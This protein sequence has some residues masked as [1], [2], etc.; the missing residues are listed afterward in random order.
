[1]RV[2]LRL[3]L[4]LVATCAPVVPSSRRRTWRDQW[5]ADLWHYAQWL[6]AHGSAPAPGSSLAL[7]ARSAGCI[8]HACALRIDDWSLRMVSHDLKFACRM[9]VRRPAFTLVAILILGLGIGANAT[10]FSWVQTV[11]LQPVP[12]VDV[13]PLVSLS[14]RTTSRRNLSFSYPNFI[15]LRGARPDGL[16]DVIAFRGVAMN[17]RGDGEPRRVWG[18]LV[19]PN[20]FDVLRLRPVLGRGFLESDASA[21]DREPVAVL[22]YGAWQGLFAGDPRIVGRR[23][24]L[25]ARPF[26]V[27]GVAPEGFRGTMIGLSLDVFV[28]ITMQRA[29]MSG[30]DRLSQ[31][32]SAFL[33]VFG[34]LSEGSTLQRAQAS[35]DVVAARL[36]EAHPV[37]EGRG[38]AVEPL[39][40]TG[41]A[42]MLLPVMA[43][44]MAVV[45]VVLLIAC[46]NL[47]GLLL[48]RAAGRQRE[49]AVRLAVG[50]S[51]GRLV[52]QLLLESVL[53]AAAGGVAGVV[54]AVWTS[55]TLMTFMPPT[56]FPVAFDAG[57]DLGVVMFAIAVTFVT[58]L[59]FGLLPALRASRPDVNAV[60]KD[61]AGSVGGGAAR[62][63]I[64]NALVVAQVAL[65]LVLLVCAALFVR[66]LNHARSLDPGFSL[67]EGVMAAVD[68]LPN[69]YDAVRGT[70][71]HHRLLEQVRALP[72]VEA[73]TI[74]SNMP[75]DIGRGSEM[76]VDIEGY[77]PAPNEEVD[78]FYNRVGPSY[79]DTMGIPIV[80]GRPLDHRDIDGSQLSVVVNETMAGRYW[81]G[82]DPIGRTIRF[83]A[84]PAIVVG[85]ATDGKYGQ[86][87]EPAQN[88]MYVPI[89]QFFR[90]DA[91]L[92]VR[93]DGNSAPV[94]PALHAEVKK[95]DPNL[96]LFDVRP[97]S[98]HLK[99][100]VFIP[101]LASTVLGLFGVLA[102]LLAIVGLYSV[103]ALGVAQRTREI[104]VRVAM[105]ATRRDILRLVLRQGMKLTIIGLAAGLALSVA[106]AQALRSQLIGVGPTDIISFA[107]TS[108]VL[109]VV[110]LLACAI[111]ARRAARL[112]PVRALRLD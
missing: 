97:V 66:G 70:A 17:L 3:A 4:A 19:S 25:N 34:R 35:L 42:G 29:F 72:H 96:P 33:F 54:V 18:Q 84:G 87:N 51:R 109:L 52:R 63:R 60:L 74:A 77:T 93:T 100:A 103:V 110:A 22:S 31:R 64:R 28:P 6:D 89:A 20:F 73:A 14:G 102:L 91:I 12:G 24:T 8:P 10:I 44:L 107:G 83:G 15:D 27:I 56:P 53:L 2:S 11:L 57:V 92:I 49:I 105:G 95:L 37:N 7:L 85:V 23:I 86:M 13:S 65:S 98:E 101:R 46:A 76:S 5:R 26:T 71:F 9:L 30:Q 21:L 78:A 68:L 106:A 82:Q 58:A 104:G 62:A 41:A 75:L 43:T 45:G 81:P 55:G 59:A 47:A 79:F 36:A 38:I 111:P 39:W 48:A 16:D 108:T 112:D 90:H 88:H 99:L 80:S 94:I 32:G 61:A 69:G 50:A 67:L 1:M 40:Q